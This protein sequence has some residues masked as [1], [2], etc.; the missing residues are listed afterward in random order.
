MITRRF[1]AM[2]LWICAVVAQTPPPPQAPQASDPNA[3]QPTKPEERA[4]IEGNIYSLKTGAPLGK[5]EIRLRRAESNKQSSFAATSDASGHY[6]LE[7]IDPGQYSLSAS[8]NG[9]VTTSYGSEAK[10][11]T[12]TMITLS[13]AQHMTKADIKLSPQAV[14]TGRVVDE[15]NEPMSNV[16]VQL[17]KRGY[18][19]G[20]RTL[21]PSGQGTSNDKGEY[22]IFGVGPGR[23]WAVAVAGR[24]NMME[25]S[26]IRSSKNGQTSYPATYYPN[27]LSLA[28]GSQL[29]IAAGAEIDGID[30]HLAKIKSYTVSGKLLNASSSRNI[31]VQLTPHDTDGLPAWDRMKIAMVDSDG[32][33]AFRGVQAG[34]YDLTASS[35][36]MENRQSTHAE[37]IVSDSDVDVPLAFGENP[38]LRGTV[39]SDDSTETLKPGISVMLRPEGGLMMSAMFPSETKDD[40]TFTVKSVSL[41]RVRLMLFPLPDGHYIKSI[42]LGSV[43]SEDTALDLTNGVPGE[44]T[45]TLSAKGATISGSVQDDGQKP[46]TN[47]TIVLVPDNRQLQSRYENASPDQN[48]QFT[49]KDI[50][51]GSYKLFAFDNVEHGIWLDADWLKPYESKGESIEVK[52]SEKASKNLVII[53]T[54]ES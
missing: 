22:R 12:S 13:P 23:Y 1:A 41:A 3:A 9:Y 16:S 34:H 21:W 19:N 31:N 11:Q 53:V 54:D 7:N 43:E 28:E 36:S 15:D 49:I 39:R 25:Q 35:F 24:E 48:G 40:G 46:V 5:A 18:Q 44:L 45:I 2:L 26:E 6:I 20:K 32:K 38:D 4:I 8:R 50:A 33:Y 37:A 29:Q 14:V 17:M 10:K 47:G 27:G 51:P 30:F 52:E 42:Q